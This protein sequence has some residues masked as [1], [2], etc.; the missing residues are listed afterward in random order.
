LGKVAENKVM[1]RLA[2]SAADKRMGWDIM[3]GDGEY[4]S[5]L[6]T[7]YRNRVADDE[8]WREELRILL[9][10]DGEYG[11]FGR[12]IRFLS[13]FEDD[14]RLREEWL[15][16]LWCRSIRFINKHWEE[17]ERFAKILQER[18]TLDRN[19]I[20]EVFELIERKEA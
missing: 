5:E 20:F 14:E 3:G 1:V 12:A 7:C 9:E 15:L 18:R 19:G 10:E 11:D 8:A 6:H 2:G 4:Y 16:R 13:A 17:I